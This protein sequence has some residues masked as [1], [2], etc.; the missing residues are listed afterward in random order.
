MDIILVQ[1][2]WWYNKFEGLRAERCIHI[3][4][5]DMKFW[6]PCCVQITVFMGSWL[7]RIIS[8]S[9]IFQI[10]NSVNIRYF[11]RTGIQT[12]A[13]FKTPTK[14]YSTQHRDNERIFVYE[15][16]SC[17][18]YNIPCILH[19]S[20]CTCGVCIKYIYFYSEN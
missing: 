14:I 1:K 5:S 16:E 4:Y 3:K 11:Q 18:T 12:T 13:C 8:N 10:Y 15:G 7:E 6:T 17:T 2:F 9:T 19:S 20:G